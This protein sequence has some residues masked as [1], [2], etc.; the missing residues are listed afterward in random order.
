MITNND[1]KDFANKLW[2]DN[3]NVLISLCLGNNIKI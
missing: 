3:I 1:L 2:K